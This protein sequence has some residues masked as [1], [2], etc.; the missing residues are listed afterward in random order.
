MVDPNVT[1][2]PI[3]SVTRTHQSAV[4][5]SRIGFAARTRSQVR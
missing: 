5:G 2:P 1:G 3:A 4:Q